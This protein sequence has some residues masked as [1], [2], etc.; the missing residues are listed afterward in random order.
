ML[1]HAVRGTPANGRKAPELTHVA[2][3]EWIGAGR[4]RNEPAA[5]AQWIADPQQFKPGVNMPAH[6]VPPEQLAA[7]GR[8]RQPALPR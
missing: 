4:L 8:R 7:R 5:M 2:S 6:Q 3:R 1:C